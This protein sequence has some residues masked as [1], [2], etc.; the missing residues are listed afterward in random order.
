[1]AEKR[2]LPP[3]AGREP[4]AKRRVSEAATP[5]QKKKAATPRA[6]T[7]PLEPIE[8][9]LP[10]KMRDGEPLPVVRVRQPDTL[11]DKEYQS[12]AERFDH[13]DLPIEKEMAKRW[14]PCP[15]LHEAQEDQARTNREEQPPKDSMSRIGACDIT[16][17][18]HLFGAMLYIVKDPTVPPPIQYATPQRPMV[19]Y[20]HPNNFQQ[21]QPYPS[22][23]SGQRRPPYPPGPPGRPP[24]GY[25]GNGP[26]NQQR[27]PHPAPSPSGSRP[28]GQNAPPGQPA[29]QNPDPVIQMLATRAAADPELKALMR[30]VASSQA[31][32]EQLR[33]FQAHIDEL[34]A[35]IKSREQQEQRQQASAGTPTQPKTTPQPATPAPQNKPTL[36]PGS[37]QKQTSASQEPQKDQK[38]N[39]EPTT[40]TDT[41]SKK[42]T[43]GPASSETQ[44][45]GPAKSPSE[46]AQPSAQP[47]EAGT[48]QGSQPSSAPQKPPAEP[49]VKQESAAAG[50]NTSQPAPTGSTQPPAST[51]APKPATIGTPISTST[52]QQPS[53]AVRPP[54][55]PGN[56]QSP[57]P[58][59]GPPYPPYQQAP[60]GVQPPIQSRP[61][62][63]NSPGSFYRPPAPPTRPAP[64]GYK[65]VVFEF[66]S[67]LTPY[68]SSTSGHA[69][70]GDRY[71]FP[72][73]S[74]L[75]WLPNECTMLASFLVVRK[76]D[77]NTPF[78]I[79]SAQDAASGRGKGKGASKSKKGKAEKGKDGDETPAP[80]QAAPPTSTETPTKAE[81]SNKPDANPAS[82][83]PSGT[84]AGT[85]AEPAA[86]ETKLKE[87]WQP[88]TFR[89]HA[90]QSK[91]LEPLTRVVKP[92]DEVRKYMNEIMDR[93]ERAPD[94]FPAFRLPRE[95][96]R[97]AFESEGTP[98]SVTNAAAASRIRPSRAGVKVEEESEVENNLPDME[99]EEEE[100]KDFYGDP[101]GLPPL[102][103]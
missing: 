72:E 53:P 18:P 65:A 22:P 55:P 82:Q 88:V 46:G 24:Q 7:P 61:P 73:Y 39:Q 11:S 51:P 58:R 101:M 68:G 74:I 91:I 4:A 14:H 48:P 27:G 66:T 3:R 98:V 97:E 13:E 26:N 102:R 25:P 33:A 62:Q 9:P 67:P 92:A 47:Q 87:Y 81:P 89:I 42:P 37:Q 93:A 64:L 19:H 76:V 20:G 30:V 29:K 94:G 15:L 45:S 96:A 41:P 99:E 2:K 1:M 21:Y 50:S 12:F 71:L 57:A 52:P 8:A 83:E 95:E 75:E 17:G 86:T 32:Q 85:P 38:A 31:T 60:N 6:P 59:P 34:N 56:A 35:I 80:G 103:T 54:Q 84:P 78:P 23:S 49:A 43:E 69:G 28:P 5:A 100:L 77:P 40:K 10:S 70:S 63:Y 44:P 36:Q 16:V 79:E 90:P